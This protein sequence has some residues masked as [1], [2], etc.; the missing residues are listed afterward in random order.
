M[1]D[2]YLFDVD[3]TLVMDGIIPKSAIEAINRLKEKNNIVML[4]TGRCLGQLKYVL[5]KI[6]FDGAILNN[7]SVVVVRN[8]I[9]FKSPINK[10]T[11]QQM[12]ADNLHLGLLTKDKY[13]AFN[14]DE[15]FEQFYDYFNI[16][17]AI[18][19]KKDVP[20]ED[21][22]SLGVYGLDL[23]QLDVTRYND[24]KFIRVCPIGFDVVN[25]CI[26][27][28][29]GIKF[30]RK[31]FPSSKIISFGDNYNDIEMLDQSDISIVMGEANLEVQKYADYVTKSPL[32]DG[33]MYALKN[34]VRSI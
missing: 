26:S 30:L 20:L 16:E 18:T 22:Y 17:K 31:K 8:E 2:I 7:G 13:F 19:I 29:S 6:D 5:E 25:K 4:S 21:V 1:S 15:V 3:G 34:F 32:D 28:A 9:I 11:I 23:D 27:K 24:L 12:I 10:S 33:I 14:D